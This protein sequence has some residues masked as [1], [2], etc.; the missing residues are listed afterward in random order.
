MASVL[1]GLANNKGLKEVL[2]QYES[3]E[4]NTTLATAWTDI[5]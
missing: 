5:L 2:I 1:A 4:T 3:S